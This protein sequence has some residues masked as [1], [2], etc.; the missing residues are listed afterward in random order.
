MA[1]VLL[2]V[3]AEQAV[4]VDPIVVTSEKKP[5]VAG[6]FDS[7]HGTRGSESFL[8]VLKF[9]NQTLA[10]ISG[11]KIDY[12]IFIQR[13]KLGAPVTDP[14]P[15]DHITG[16][17]TID[18]LNNNKP[19]T[20]STSQFTLNRRNLKSGFYYE[21]GGRVKA[22]DSVVGLWVQVKQNGQL[23]AEYTN[24]PTV[25]TRGWPTQPSQ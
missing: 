21:R 5:A 14:G 24:P 2:G 17:G 1:L 22:E 9:Q 8:Y 12:A 13:P 11:L 20:I 25:K 4:A 6:Q 19:Q 7:G 23:I 16:V 18:V 10:D 15:V 3:A